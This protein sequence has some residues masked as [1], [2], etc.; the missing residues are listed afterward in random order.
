VDIWQAWCEDV[1]GNA[2]ECGHYLPEE[3]PQETASAILEFFG[4]A[5]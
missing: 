5:D 4:T 2:I 1:R 3:A